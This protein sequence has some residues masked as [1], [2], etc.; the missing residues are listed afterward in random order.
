MLKKILLVIVLFLFSANYFILYSQNPKIDGYKGIWY[1]SGPNTKY[2]YRF[3]GGV[4]TFG[5]RHRPIAIYSPK[6]RKTFFVY[7]GTTNAEEQHL[8][9]MISYFDHRSHM[10][11]KPVIVYDKMGVKEPYDNASLAID[12]EGILWV[13]VSGYLRTRPGMIF[14]STK[15]YS[16]DAFEMVKEIEMISP[17][18]WWISGEGFFMF[19]S[20]LSKGLELWC[21]SGTDGKS[22]T[23]GQQLAS[24]GGSLQISDVH[25]GKIVTAF[26]YFPKGDIDRQTNLYFLQSDDLGK[27]WQTIDGKPVQIPLT[28]VENDAI[29]RNYEK[30]GKEVYLSDLDFDSDGN[31]VILV[32]VSGNPD[33]GPDAGLKNWFVISRKVGTWNFNKVC[34]STHNFDR[35]SIHIEG[36]EWKVIGPTEQGPQL[37]GTGGEV[38]L[39][40]SRNGGAEWQKVTD[41][42]N[43]SI[44][45]NSFVRHPLNAQKDF[46][47]LWTDGNANELS[48]SYLY[49]TNKKCNKVWMLPYEMKEDFRRPVRIR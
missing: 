17:Q 42:T 9:I 14:R 2:G 3:S 4:S 5:S 22:W 44:N 37:Y 27:T 16:I 32:I 21:S 11:P 48:K 38:A 18:P 49:F 15:P 12:D 23:A 30:E 35:G 20:K 29:I 24:M 46:F 47:A 39:W 43:N 25:E 41:V 45:N 34:E 6:A 33:P 10:V 8:L 26:N 13:F 36:S 40:I 31:P 7:G 28:D 1:S 19:Y